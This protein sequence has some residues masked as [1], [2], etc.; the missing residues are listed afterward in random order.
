MSVYK[1][2]ILPSTARDCLFH[3]QVLSVGCCPEI[4]T[5]V[6]LCGHG[7]SLACWFAITIIV[8]IQLLNNPEFRKSIVYF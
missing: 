7:G 6:C 4:P 8:M 1:L 2:C 5:I 3:F